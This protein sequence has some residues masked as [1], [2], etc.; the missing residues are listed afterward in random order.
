MR[1]SRL[2]GRLRQEKP[3]P[4]C[5]VAQAL[6]NLRKYNPIVVVAMWRS[7]GKGFVCPTSSLVSRFVEATRRS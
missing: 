4:R 7:R 2:L 6:A 1:L 3:L 5:L